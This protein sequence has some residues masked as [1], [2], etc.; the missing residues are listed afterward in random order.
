MAFAPVDDKGANTDWQKEIE[1]K[2]AVSTNHKYFFF[3]RQRTYDLQ[4][5]RQLCKK[6]RDHKKYR[7]D[8][9]H[10]AGLAIDQYAFN[11][12][13]KFSLTSPIPTP[14]RTRSL[15]LACPVTGRALSAGVTGQEPDGTFF[16]TRE[17]VGITTRCD[18]EQQ[19]DERQEEQSVGSFTP[20]S[21]SLLG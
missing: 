2:T 20:R 5:Q 10:W 3:R 8:P 15:I 12:R 21:S 6:G 1:R 18:D 4:R 13:V 7:P 14:M 11:D 16:E 19:P 17:R 9:C